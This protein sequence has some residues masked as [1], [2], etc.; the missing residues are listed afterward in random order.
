VENKFLPLDSLG[1]AQ[2]CYRFDRFAA[3]KIFTIDN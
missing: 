1:Y 3:I 2:P